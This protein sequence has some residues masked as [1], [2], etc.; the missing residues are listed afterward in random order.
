M[1]NNLPN[2][3]ISSVFIDQNVCTNTNNGNSTYSFTLPRTLMTTSSSKMTLSTFS[4][5]YSWFN[6]TSAIGNNVF[7]LTW[8]DGYNSGGVNRNSYSYI[9]QITIP[10]GFYSITELNSLLQDFMVDKGLYLINSTGN[11]VYYIEIVYNIPRYR[12]QFN[13]YPLPTSLPTGWSVP[14]TGTQNIVLGGG[15]YVVPQLLIPTNVNAG[16][17]NLFTFFGLNQSLALPVLPDTINGTMYF[18]S[19]LSYPSTVTSTNG[20]YLISKTNG[21]T[22]STITNPISMV[23]QTTWIVFSTPL[24]ISYIGAGTIDLSFR[25]TLVDGTSPMCI[26]VLD[27]VSSTGT[28]TSLGSYS[29]ALSGTNTDY[30]QSLAI[31]AR[32]IAKNSTLR[33][34][35]SLSGITNA[36]GFSIITNNNTYPF[37]LFLNVSTFF[38]YPWSFYNNFAVLP[39][40]IELLRVTAGNTNDAPII[41]QSYLPSYAPRQSNV[42]SICLTCDLI[43]NP[44][45]STTTHP[46]SSFVLS[47]QN[48]DKNFGENINGQAYFTTWIPLMANQTVNILNFTLVDQDGNLLKLEDP[49]VNIEVL[50]SDVKY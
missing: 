37:K 22:P 33:L 18:R 13:S 9:Y 42:H 20:S 32:S 6:I 4:V 11:Y 26:A 30:T 1:N 29:F 2:H 14:T 35:M 8:N 31:A 38:R 25:G 7:Y 23:S 49:D 21:S 39:T 28:I 27:I 36:S 46:V 12:I 50:L 45:R 47:T 15:P 5:P 41:A 3:S 19:D 16:T 10:D 44:I 17:V 43:D 34:T 40:T 24:D 48:I